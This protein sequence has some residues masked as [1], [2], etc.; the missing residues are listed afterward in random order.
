M[1]IGGD[2]KE[3]GMRRILSRKTMW[4]GAAL[5]LAALAATMGSRAALASADDGGAT[6]QDQAE[7]LPVCYAR[8]VDA[9]GRAVTAPANPDLDSTTAMVD[10]NFK[11]GLE[12]F[13][14]CFAPNFSF[15]LSNRGVVSRVVPDPAKRTVKTD[16]AVQWANY[17]NNVFRG[18]GYVYTQHH[19]GSIASEIRGNEGTVSSYLIATHVA[20]PTSKRTGVSVTYGTYTDKVARINGRW[21]ITHRTLDTIAG[22]GIPAGM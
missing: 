4:A 1:A 8:G 18:A 13:R 5:L 16:A 20:G 9:I 19:M 21:L 11:E 12:H 7:D 15:S 14:R 10:P 2:C 3:I 6:A 17:V 22:A